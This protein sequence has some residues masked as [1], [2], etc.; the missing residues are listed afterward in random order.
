[1][2]SLNISLPKALKEYVEGQVAEGAYSTPSEYVRTL[3][4][5]DRKKRAHETLEVALLRGVRSGQAREVEPEYWA[6]KRKALRRQHK[7]SKA[8][9]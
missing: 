5:E 8:R 1:M 9:D 2:A 6:R 4:R 3:I 7:P